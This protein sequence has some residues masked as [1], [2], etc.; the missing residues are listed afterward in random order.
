[1]KTSEAQEKKTVYQKMLDNLD[2]PLLFLKEG[3]TLSLMFQIVNQEPMNCE[4]I[5]NL[6]QRVLFA[7]RRICVCNSL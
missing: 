7:V 1:M 5:F 3:R 4:H 2:Q 6:S